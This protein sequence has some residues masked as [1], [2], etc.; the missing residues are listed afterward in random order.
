MLVAEFQKKNTSKRSIGDGTDEQ[1]ATALLIQ[2]QNKL[3]CTALTMAGYNGD[4]MK[5]T[6]KSAASTRVVT[7]AHS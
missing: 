3:A 6:L 5:L 1:Q 2:E 4:M 7:F